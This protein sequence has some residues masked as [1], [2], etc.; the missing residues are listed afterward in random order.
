MRPYI[1]TTANLKQDNKLV[2]CRMSNK[3]SVPVF[4]FEICKPIK[5]IINFASIRSIQNE[6]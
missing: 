2:S 3:Y 4:L 6:Y 5:M 1:E